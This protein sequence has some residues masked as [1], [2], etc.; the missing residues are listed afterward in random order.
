MHSALAVR[1]LPPSPPLSA[2]CA[3]AIDVAGGT[4]LAHAT[5]GAL[6][7]SPGA[8]CRARLLLRGYPPGC[9]R[10]FVVLKGRGRS[11]VIGENVGAWGAKFAAPTL[12][13]LPEGEPPLGPHRCSPAAG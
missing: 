13:L 1:E 10:A 11:A 8:W 5:S 4:Y 6:S 7:C 2:P 9:R 3:A 12:R